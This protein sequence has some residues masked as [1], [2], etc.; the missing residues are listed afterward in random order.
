MATEATPYS[1][2]RER[3]PDWGEQMAKEV[4]IWTVSLA[5]LGTLWSATSPS[6]EFNPSAIYL[7]VVSGVV[8]SAILRIHLWG[9]QKLANLTK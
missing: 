4:A 8:L 7:I 2:I 6:V 3:V 5:F 9:Y 1:E